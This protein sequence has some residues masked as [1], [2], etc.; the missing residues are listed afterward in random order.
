SSDGLPCVAQRVW[1]MPVAP[2]GIA[3][4]SRVS[5]FWSLPFARMTER[6]P[7]PSTAR[8]AESYPRYSSL[9]NPSTRRLAH[10]SSPT[11][12]TMP[13]IQ[14]P[15]RLGRGPSD[16]QPVYF[17]AFFGAFFSTQPSMLRCLPALTANEPGGTSSRTVVPVP[18]YA[19]LPT[20]TGATSCESLPMKA[21]SSMVVGCLFTPS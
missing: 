20:F 11:Y 7:L 2:C 18:T 15:F 8:P 9:R 3:S 16:R 6:P 4:L 12:P 13:H 5:R 1:P 14:E 10:S 21:R 19:P 17:D